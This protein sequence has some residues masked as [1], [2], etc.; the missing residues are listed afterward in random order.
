MKHSAKSLFAIILSLCMLV[1]LMPI[2]VFADGSQWVTFG[3]GDFNGN[4]AVYNVNG[5]TV[6]VTVSGANIDNGT[7]YLPDNGFGNITFTVGGD[8]DPNTMR[9]SL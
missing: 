7:V 4:V 5:N 2:G 8:F 6:T 3:T 9:V 1:S